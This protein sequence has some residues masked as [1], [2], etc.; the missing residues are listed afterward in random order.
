MLGPDWRKSTYSHTN[1]C[2]EVAF[3]EVTVL[4]GESWGTRTRVIVRDSKDPAGPTLVFTP[5]EWEAFI[6]GIRDNQFNLPGP[7]PLPRRV[8]STAPTTALTDDVVTRRV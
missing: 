6:D 5:A 7:P 3:T 4:H 1:G 8:A 2:V